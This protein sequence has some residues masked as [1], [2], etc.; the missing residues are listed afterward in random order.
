MKI[1]VKIFP[2]DGLCSESEELEIQLEE[3]RLGELIALINKRLG[4]DLS[5]I[6]KLMFLRN[7]RAIDREQ[8]TV[9]L[10]GDKIW[11]LPQ[12]SGG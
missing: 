9:L 7:G 11:L 2:C 4:T 5:K 1:Q 8:D 12:I 6:E 10:D 3:G